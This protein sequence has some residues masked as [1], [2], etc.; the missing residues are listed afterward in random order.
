MLNKEKAVP[1]YNQLIQQLMDEIK[2]NMKAGD[3][4]PSEREICQTYQVSRTT[5]R[6]ALNELEELGYIYKHHGKGTFVSNLWQQMND[7]SN[8]Y[9][10]TEHMK[11]LGKVPRTEVLEFSITYP[12][13]VVAKGLQVNEDDEVYKLVR[14]RIADDLPMMY[15]ISYIPCKIFKGLTLEMIQEKPL[16][17]IFAQDYQKD[18]KYADEEFSASLVKEKEAKYLA[19]NVGD[20]CLRIERQTY[21]QDNYI[22]EFT[23]SVARSD[24]F[25]YRIRHARK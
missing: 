1:L 9:S 14:L 19:V 7:L 5:V 17:N 12:N 2:N 8:E 18:I 25:V 21:C 13:P 11:G 20:P 22:I 23:L 16:Y 24:Q 4:L 15:E 6:L 3:K 10:F